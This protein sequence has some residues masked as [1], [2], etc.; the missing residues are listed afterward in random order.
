M[1]FAVDHSKCKRD[2]KLDEK[3][4]KVVFQM[5]QQKNAEVVSSSWFSNQDEN[6]KLVPM[7]S[8][9]GKIHSVVELNW[10]ELNWIYLFFCVRQN[11]NWNKI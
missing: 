7:Y 8:Q 6:L 1:V 10:I 9:Q 11:Y 4:A 3:S 2:L 5:L